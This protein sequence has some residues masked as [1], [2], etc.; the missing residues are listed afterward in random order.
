[1]TLPSVPL[2]DSNEVANVIYPEECKEDTTE[3]EL[4]PSVELF[5]SS[6]HK[7]KKEE[8]V[9]VRHVLFGYKLISVQDIKC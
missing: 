5:K 9:Y 7:N 8:Y 2:T 1:M 4:S 6:K 3:C